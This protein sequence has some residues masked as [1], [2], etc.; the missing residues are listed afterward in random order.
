VSSGA[1]LSGP[2]GSPDGRLIAVVVGGTTVTLFDAATGVL[3]RTLGQGSQPSFSPDGSQVAFVS[4]DGWISVVPTD[5][6]TARKLVQGTSPAWGGGDGPGPAVRSTRLRVRRGKVAVKVACSGS[7]A[8]RGTLRIKKGKRTLGS[9]SYR[10]SAGRRAT[11]S[12]K[13]SRR[14]AK[15]IARSR[16]HTV[17]VEL[18]PRGG[19]VIATKLDLRR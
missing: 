1:T 16:S 7:E 13:P 15:T 5:G 8:C 18:E 2:D 6:G 12:V 11:V 10:V 9:R 4:A 14:G 3:V 19:S 17:S